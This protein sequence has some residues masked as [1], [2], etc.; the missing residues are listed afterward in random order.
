MKRA[1]CLLLVV[2][3]IF[4]LT[5]CNPT[6]TPSEQKPA[7]PTNVREEDT[8]LI[9]WD[10]VEGAIGYVIN[11]DG[12]SHSL[13]TNSYQAPSVTEE[14]TYIIYA[15][16][17][18]YVF[19]DPTETFTFEARQAIVPVPDLSG[20]TVAIEG[21][22]EIFSGKTLQLKA[23]VEGAEDKSV[24]WKVTQGGDVISVDENGLVTA[25]Q[26]EGDVIVRVE[27]RSNANSEKFASKVLTV[28]AKPTLTQDMLD[29]LKGDKIA[30]D[31][32]INISLYTL[33]PFSKLESTHTTTVR[34]RMDGDYWYGAYINS[35]TNAETGLYIKNDNGIASNVGL[36]FN[37][38]EEY[39]P[40]EEN[41]EEVAWADS[42]L[43]NNFTDLTVSDFTFNEETWRFEYN[44][45]NSFAEKVIASANP[46]DFVVNGFALIISG[47]SI[48]G[49]YA[50]SGDDYSV[51]DGYRAIQE[52]TVAITVGESV[53]VPKV[54]KYLHMPIHDKLQSAIDKMQTL[55]SYTLDYKEI[56]ASIYT[57]GVVEAGFV[58]TVTADTMHFIPYSVSYTG[59]AS[60][61]V[62]VN[63]PD[64]SA[65]YGFRTF[66]ENL[67]NSYYNDAEKGGFTASRAYNGSINEVRPSFDFAA[68]I[69]TSYYE[70]SETGETTYYVDEAMSA[71]ASTFY[72][73]VG[74]DKSLYGIFAARGYVSETKS[75]TPYVVVSADGYITEACFYFNMGMMYGVIELEYSK[76]N[77]T[78]TPSDISFDGYVVRQVPTSWSEI[79]FIV[80]G[81]IAGTE[82]D[83]MVNAV[84]VYR[85]YLNVNSEEVPFFGNA[86]GDSYAFAMLTYRKPASQSNIKTTVQ[87]FYDVPLDVD[88]S[89]NSSLDKVNS[90]LESLG[91]V[92]NEYGEFYKDVT[93]G[94]LY[95]APVDNQLDLYIY[96]WIIPSVAS[97]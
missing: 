27:A 18:G 90:Y 40:M 88:Y 93:G 43:Y 9:T 20:V 66:G 64:P 22:S 54:V 7:T 24:T 11:I 35:I 13:Q 3:M 1:L 2:A 75:F 50:K 21:G 26:V 23:I 4:S 33:P 12:K 82:T 72:N 84:D 76:F 52:L 60:D 17:E 79:E 85:D 65:S 57:S 28:L 80:P 91:F 97:N 45:D 46:Y 15:V 5:A 58:E 29:A 69:F 49:I 8:G 16:G 86:L 47:D 6:T 83:E 48:S 44:G 89:I 78:E 87:F 71:V 77:A 63:T 96:V 31:G 67:Y 56:V 70:D 74:N 41:G 81:D 94:T 53:E 10:A 39:F 73:C 38:E 19:S 59:T 92:R 95:V 42:G 62:E 55:E 14:F 37:N 36:N 32:F 34:T 25:Q 51:V 68:A 61:P 30:F